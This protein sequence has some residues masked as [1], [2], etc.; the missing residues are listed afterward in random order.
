MSHRSNS[1]QRKHAQKNQDRL[2]LGDEEY[3]RIEMLAYRVLK[4]PKPKIYVINNQ[5]QA[6]AQT[7]PAQQTQANKP[8]TKTKITPT[9]SKTTCCGF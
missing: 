6:Q 9:I 7:S 3:K 4:N 1:S 8:S 2:R 5:P